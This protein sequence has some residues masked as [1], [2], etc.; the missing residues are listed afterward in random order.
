MSTAAGIPDFRSP[1]GLYG[2]SA[3]L[4]QRFTYLDQAS[5]PRRWQQ[6][7]L[8]QDVRSALTL[9]LFEVNPLPYHEIRRGLIIGLGEGQW[10]LTLAHVLPEILN[11]HGKLHLLASQNIDGLDHKV[12]SDPSKLYNP[13]GLMSVLVSEPLQQPLCTSPQD[14]IYQRYVQLVKSNIKDIYTDRPTRKG[15]S[16]HLWPA[17]QDSTPITLEMFGD[18]L[19]EAFHNARQQEKQQQRFSVKPGSVLFDCMLWDRNAAGE[20]CNAFR[21]VRDCDLVLVMGTSLSG[22]TIDNVAHMAGPLGVPRIVMDLGDAPVKSLQQ[23]GRWDGKKDCHLQGPLDD[24]VLQ[25]LLQLQWL[26]DVMEFLPLLC[27]GSL[28]CLAAFLQT[29]APTQL[30]GEWL[31]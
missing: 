8:E 2:T 18:L 11:R 1:G 27:L 21:E 28:K 20:H 13:H 17:P 16:S 23:E 24:S 19:P 29:H 10:K 26:P 30:A 31:E 6:Q 25:L 5:R 14:P 4:L 12:V 9:E 3:T 15:R 22:L 7:Q